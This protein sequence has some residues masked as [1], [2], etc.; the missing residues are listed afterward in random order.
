[1]GKNGERRKGEKME[2]F[3]RREFIRWAVASACVCSCSFLDWPNPFSGLNLWNAGKARAEEGHVKEEMFYRK[4]NSLRIECETCPRRCQV[5]EGKRGYCGNKE[6]QGGK[7]YSLVYNKVCAAHIDPIEKKPFYHYLPGTLAFSLAAAGCNFSCKF[8]QNWEI[9]QAR[10]EEIPH[11]FLTPDRAINICHNQSI[12]TI[13]YTY[14]EPTTFYT[15]MYDMAKTARTAGIGSVMISNGFMNEVPLRELC[16]HLTAVRID[17]KSFNNIFYRNIC[18]G[19]LAPVLATLQRLKEI[20]IWFEIIALIIP[21]L[22]DNPEELQKMCVWLK[23]NLGSDVPIHFTRFHPMYQIQNLP[24]TPV[25]TL[26]MA[27]ETALTAGLHFPYIGNV[28]GHEGDNTYCPS[29][30]K[31]LIQRM[32]FAILE[33]AIEKGSCKFC[34]QPIPGVWSKEQI[35]L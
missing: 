25:K 10:P 1:M 28:P 26:E 15:S 27:R 32:G 23:A 4:L 7:Y 6:N 33:N 11:D 3:S 30:K 31:V 12:P 14:S 24:S 5:G 9:S 34:H 20:G 19:E 18:S 17:L 2:K 35:P 29:C 21:T 8:C 16:K 13:A 22:N